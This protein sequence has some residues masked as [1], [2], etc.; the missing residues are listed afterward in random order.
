LP[1]RLLPKL[2]LPIHC[3]TRSISFAKNAWLPLI[4]AGTGRKCRSAIGVIRMVNH[5]HSDR[6][7]SQMG[8]IWNLMRE[9]IAWQ[10]VPEK[11][12]SRKVSRKFLTLN[13]FFPA[14]QCQF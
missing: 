14:R 1:A 9:R 2:Y 5:A 3:P 11:H 13:S 12:T 6:R 8:V 4:T 7:F 10:L